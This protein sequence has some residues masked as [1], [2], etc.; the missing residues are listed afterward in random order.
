MRA[1]LVPIL[2]GGRRPYLGQVATR[3]Q[4]LNSGGFN[5]GSTDTMN[6]SAHYARDDIGALQLVYC[7]WYVKTS[8]GTET[9]TGGTMSLKTSI[10]YPVGVFTQVK[11]GGSA[12]WTIAS[13][14][15][16]VSDL[17]AVS[18]PR[19]ALFFVRTS[20]HNAS[21]VQ[22]MDQIADATLGD[23]ISFV[24]TD[25]TMSG[26]VAND[27]PG[28]CF[29]PSAII[30]QTRKRSVLVLGDSTTL[31]LKDT[32]DG[33]T[34]DM[35][36]VARS[37]GGS[38]AYTNGGT[39]SDRAAWAKTNS[40]KR[41]A[42]SAYFSDIIFGYQK[43]DPT[44]TF[45]ADII[46]LANL[47]PVTARKS[48]VTSTPQTSGAWTLVN[49]SD[50]TVVTNYTS[51]NAFLAAVPQPFTRCFDINPAVSIAGTPTK[52]FAPSYT[53]DGIHET[54]T[55]NLAIKASGIIQASVFA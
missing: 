23:R 27:V 20:L 45:Q 46:T 2:F 34:G 21:G 33:T 22:Y 52:W 17:T 6:R 31:G 50:Q 51:G 55:A 54:Q 47:Y 12:T 36:T 16:G 38:V 25:L 29:V 11:G 41:I 8:D 24:A 37:I 42:L 32:A 5:S 39:P 14:S 49:G 18:I 9:A 4:I 53:A 15:T 43:N 30:G 10:E 13:G 19:G 26:T 44:G 28:Y 35:G 7:N 3:T 1:S 40:T 48:A